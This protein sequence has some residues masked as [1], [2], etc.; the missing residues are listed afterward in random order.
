M[1]DSSSSFKVGS[2]DFA[3]PWSSLR[4]GQQK[5]PKSHVGWVSFFG[6][7]KTINKPAS[8]HQPSSVILSLGDNSNIFGCSPGK[9]WGFIRSNLTSQPLLSSNGKMGWFNSTTKTGAFV[10]HL[11]WG[12]WNFGLRQTP[13]QV[14]GSIIKNYEGDTAKLET[15]IDARWHRELQVGPGWWWFFFGAR[16]VK[17]MKKWRMKKLTKCSKNDMSNVDFESIVPIFAGMFHVIH[18]GCD[19]VFPC[20]ERI[21]MDQ[22]C[23]YAGLAR[24][25]HHYCRCYAVIPN[26]HTS[27]E[28]LFFVFDG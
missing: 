2:Q 14:G 12:G 4:S 11:F 5:H 26:K 24:L 18:W 7:L 3:F 20:Y 6:W 25:T 15:F 27:S 1:N 23:N 8:K 22:Q 17:R 28:G 9:L 16:D 21:G 19:C 13:L 10:P